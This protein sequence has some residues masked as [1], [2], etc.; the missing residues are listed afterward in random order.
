MWGGGGSGDKA[1]PWSD[2][3][4]VTF[5]FSS[6]EGLVV[7]EPPYVVTLQPTDPEILFSSGE[8]LVLVKSN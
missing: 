6:T 1:K 2:T 5:T 3:G 4:V 7:D 8:L